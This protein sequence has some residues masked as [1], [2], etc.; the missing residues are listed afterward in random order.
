M[1]PTACW[2]SPWEL[3]EV[4]LV[5]IIVLTMRLQTPSAPLVLALTPLLGSLCSVQWL[6]ASIHICIGQVLAEPL[7]RQLYQA[8]VSKYFLA[9]AIVSGFGGCRW[10]GSLRGA[11]SGWP[12]FQS[13]LHSF[14]LWTGVILG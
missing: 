3:L 5:D 2:F 11:V 10:D 6:A 8:P 13:L 9:S 12:F 14:F 7:K 1:G 4:W